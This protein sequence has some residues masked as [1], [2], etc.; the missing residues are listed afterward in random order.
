MRVRSA[1]CPERPSDRSTVTAAGRE[2]WADSEEVLQRCAL[3]RNVSRVLLQGRN[4]YGRQ[5]SVARIVKVERNQASRRR[6][7]RRT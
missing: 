6:S 5:S 3:G 4:T 2:R 1:R 7:G